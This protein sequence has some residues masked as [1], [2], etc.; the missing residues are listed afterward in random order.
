MRFLQAAGRSFTHK[1][2]FLNVGLTQWDR[3]R[4]EGTQRREDRAR[5]PCAL[6]AFPTR[7]QP[8]GGA[9]GSPHGAR[10]VRSGH[11]RSGDAGPGW[12]SQGWS[13]RLDVY[14]VS[15]RA[16]FFLQLRKTLNVTR[17]LFKTCPSHKTRLHDIVICSI[18]YS[19][20]HQKFYDISLNEFRLSLNALGMVLG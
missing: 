3:G 13:S 12:P 20:C 17:T 15:T 18:E 19:L 14:V 9:S 1:K 5:A 7:T 8:R 2:V 16:G 6:P 10:G 11:P 4:Q